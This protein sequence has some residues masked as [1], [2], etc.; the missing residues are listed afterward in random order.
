MTDN[1]EID[2]IKKLQNDINVHFYR[3]HVLDQP[4]I[5]DYEYDTL[6]KRLRELEARHPEMVT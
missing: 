1:A 5:S 4:L 6:I 3:Y 2:E